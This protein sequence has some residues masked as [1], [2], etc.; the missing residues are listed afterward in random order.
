M[1]SNRIGTFVLHRSVTSGASCT[2]HHPP[3]GRDTLLLDSPFS[4]PMGTRTMFQTSVTVAFEIDASTGEDV[5]L[6]I[7]DYIL[8]SH[9]STYVTRSKYKYC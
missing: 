6:I 8:N 7:H 1:D 4:Y 9:T 2:P 3:L 5:L